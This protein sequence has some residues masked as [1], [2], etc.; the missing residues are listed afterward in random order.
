MPGPTFI[1][2]AR[3]LPAPVKVIAPP[4]HKGAEPPIK[5]LETMWL[6]DVVKLTLIAEN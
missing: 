5:L 3:R 2:I 6:L 4:P 1:L